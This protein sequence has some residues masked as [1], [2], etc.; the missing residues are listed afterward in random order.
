MQ[1]MR[2]CRTSSGGVGLPHRYTVVY[3]VLCVLS[4]HETVFLPS[5]I[6]RT[7]SVRAD[8]LHPT[9]ERCKF[10]V[11]QTVRQRKPKQPQLTKVNQ[12]K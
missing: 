7:P 8:F 4:S 9:V 1:C 11:S 2:A 5:D 3:R 6:F 12:A 10:S